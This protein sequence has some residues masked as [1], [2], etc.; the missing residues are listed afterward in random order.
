MPVTAVAAESKLRDFIDHNPLGLLSEIDSSFEETNEKE[1]LTILGK[2][3]EVNPSQILKRS[4]D[5]LLVDSSG[6]VYVVEDKKETAPRETIAQILEY[7]A[8]LNEFDSLQKLLDHCFKNNFDRSLL[9]KNI[10]RG[11]PTF[12]ILLVAHDFECELDITSRYLL[13][14]GVPIN[15]IKYRCFEGAH[16]SNKYVF[17]SLFS[18]AEVGK[19]QA[20]QQTG[21]NLNLYHVTLQHGHRCRLWDDWCDIGFVSAGGGEKFG[22]QLDKLS[23]DDLVVCRVAN[24][25]FWGLGKVVGKKIKA[26]ISPLILEAIEKGKLKISKEEMFHD[27]D[28]DDCEYVVPVEWLEVKDQENAPCKELSHGQWGTCRKINSEHRINEL[29]EHFETIRRPQQ[30]N[31]QYI[32]QRIF[33]GMKKLANCDDDYKINKVLEALN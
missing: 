4:I 28:N 19:A 17:V 7:A 10:L 13:N 21:S 11:K 22:K 3:K 31:T 26:S 18:Q 25:G 15:L 27:S 2:L 16:I 29:A 5:N 23:L 1:S 33:E 14:L 24:Q 12:V 9:D 32:N 20:I 8:F 6:T 30:N